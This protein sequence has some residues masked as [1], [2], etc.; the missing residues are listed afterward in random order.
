MAEDEDDTSAEILVTDFSCR[1]VH[2]ASGWSWML[3]SWTIP[4]PCI[5]QSKLLQ[6]AREAK[7]YIEHA[8]LCNGGTKT[9]NRSINAA[10]ISSAP[11]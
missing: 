3:P 11:C 10:S 1:T 9:T 7:D 6:G 5:T 2:A 8:E 4:G